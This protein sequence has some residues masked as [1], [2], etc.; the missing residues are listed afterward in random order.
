MEQHDPDASSTEIV[1]EQ[2]QHEQSQQNEVVPSS[3][4]SIDN[5]NEED[6]EYDDD[7]DKNNVDAVPSVQQHPKK[8]NSEFNRKISTH[9]NNSSE[10]PES[11]DELKSES[12]TESES[13]LV[14]QSENE[15]NDND[16]QA[17]TAATGAAK[18]V[19]VATL[20]ENG[21]TSATKQ[22]SANKRK[23][24]KSELDSSGGDAIDA[25]IDDEFDEFSDD[26][27]EFFAGF[28]VD[29]LTHTGIE[30][31]RNFFRAFIFF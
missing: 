13:R 29:D 6:N 24:S 9:N 11:V 16:T 28:N 10:P 7:D 5:T 23:L 21:G 19:A 4:M 14:I 17:T 3:E 12:D 22:Q 26:D 30:I 18:A 15:T 27:E 1:A 2:Q 20:K 31:F 8:L 25:D